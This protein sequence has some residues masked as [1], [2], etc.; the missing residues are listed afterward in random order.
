M[1]SGYTPTELI[2]MRAGEL[3]YCLSYTYAAWHFMQRN[4]RSEEISRTIR[5]VIMMI[6]F[7]S[8]VLTL[9]RGNVWFYMGGG[10]LVLFLLSC[11]FCNCTKAG[12]VE[13]LL[14]AM[15]IFGSHVIFTVF[16]DF[17]G[18]GFGS[19]A[20][21]TVNTWY[22][23]I[24]TV[25][26][27]LMSLE[28]ILISRYFVKVF[29]EEH[30]VS[31]T[32]GQMIVFL[33]IPFLM[34]ALLLSVYQNGDV[35]LMLFGYGSMAG[36]MFGIAILH[37]LV[38]YLFGYMLEQQKRNIRYQ[39]YEQQREMM[40]HQYEELEEKYQSSRKVI[41]DVKNHIQMIG[42]LYHL[43]ELD[44]A[45]RYCRDIGGM[46]R[47]LERVTYTEHRMLNLILN[48]KL[49]GQEMK[50]VVLRIEVGDADLSFMKD[51]DVTTI[52][53]NLLDNAKEAAAECRKEK[54]L[55]LK[56]HETK[57]FLV[58]CLRNSCPMKRKTRRG[59]EGIGLINVRYVVESYGGTVHISEGKNEYQTSIMIPVERGEK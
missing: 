52:F 36:V 20:I 49:N 57:D 56:M 54:Y 55:S 6:L 59:H 3:I 39:L 16:L 10:M 47:S 53:S 9:Q 27:L 7:F 17:L 29:K 40:M 21:M 19:T 25:V 50:G 28:Y 13:T 43:G 44:A 33:L 22:F 51:I 58:I 34:L 2:I 4:L 30:M 18:F 45:D 15:G 26:Y 32:N 46:L 8:S 38:I 37:L 5:T 11:V 42:E 35:L 12:I 1:S 48:E 24:R 41:H 14:F 23:L 31:L